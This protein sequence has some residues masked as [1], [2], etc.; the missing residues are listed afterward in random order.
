MQQIN[1]NKKNQYDGV[2][3]GSQ[4]MTA[5]FLSVSLTV[6]VTNKGI[7]ITLNT[8]LQIEVEDAERYRYDGECLISA[9]ELGK[10]GLVEIRQK[11]DEFIF[12]VR[13]ISGLCTDTRDK[14]GMYISNR[15]AHAMRHAGSCL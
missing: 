7:V 13:A 5:C 14:T 10:P 9:E 11:Q 6:R 3:K 15:T 4:R 12:R 8:L 2:D 1:R